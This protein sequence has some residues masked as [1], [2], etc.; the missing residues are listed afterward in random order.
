MLGNVQKDHRF[1]KRY[2][3]VINIQRLTPSL[4]PEAF[5]I[6]KLLQVQ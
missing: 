2:T 6:H 5:S 1:N 4:P 3:I